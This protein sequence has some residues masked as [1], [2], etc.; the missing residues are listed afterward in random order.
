MQNLQPAHSGIQNTFKG[1]LSQDISNLSL[2]VINLPHLTQQKN[3]IKQFHYISS[4]AVKPRVENFMRLFLYL[5]LLLEIT[6]T[7]KVSSFH[8]HFDA[9]K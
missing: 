4:F 5:D 8:N 7:I 6:S 3:E 1:T 9:N 2:F